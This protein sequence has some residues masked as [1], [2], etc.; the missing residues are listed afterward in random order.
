MTGSKPAEE[1]LMSHLLELRSRLVKATLTLLIVFV[2]LVPFANDIYSWLA[3]P[4]LDDL[5]G[6]HIVAIKVLG[7]FTA[8]LKCAFF[9]ALMISMPM[10][11]YQLWAFVAPG[12]YKSEKR[13]ARPLLLVATMLF[14]AGCS[15]TYYLLL[16]AMFGFLSTTSPEGVV[17]TPDIGEYLDF[18]TVMFLAGGVSFEVPIAVMISVLLGW[19]KPAQ[20][21][22]WRGYVIVAIF[23]IAAVITPPDGL[24]QLMLAIPM[25]LLYEIGIIASRFLIRNRKVDATA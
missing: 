5:H 15:F 3:K 7:G 23:I 2:L 10:I 25:C 12:L 18:V 14:Y 22:E 21:S 11:L 4:L 1:S 24:S 9:A 13:L 16:P 17:N 20:L 19:V 8:P 6:G